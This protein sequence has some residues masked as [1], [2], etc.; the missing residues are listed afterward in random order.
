MKIASPEIKNLAYQ[1]L[2][3]EPAE[4]DKGVPVPRKVFSLKYQRG[5]KELK[6]KI[7]GC[8]EA[9]V[10]PKGVAEPKDDEL[11]WVKMTEFS[12]AGETEPYFR[13]GRLVQRITDDEFEISDQARE[14][15]RFYLNEWKE[16]LPELTEDGLS[17]VEQLLTQE[18]S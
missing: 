17:F 12:P 9:L 2:C 5:V 8:I 18:K 15:F 7:A 6:N 16:S 14:S 11:T 3:L 1:V 4:D 10:K 13:E